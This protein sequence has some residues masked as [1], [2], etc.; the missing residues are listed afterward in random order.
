MAKKKAKRTTSKGR[1][2]KNTITFRLKPAEI[3]KAQ[4][5]LERSGSITYTFKDIKVTKLPKA[6]DDGKLID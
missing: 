3:A 2:T 1:V 4:A 6:L 5:C